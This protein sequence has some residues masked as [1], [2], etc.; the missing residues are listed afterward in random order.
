MPLSLAAM[1]R[2][3]RALL[4]WVALLAGATLAGA[5]MFQWASQTDAAR[6]RVEQVPRV[7][8]W[9]FDQAQKDLDEN[10]VW[11]VIEGPA[12][13]IPYKVYAVLSPGTEVP[14]SSFLVASIPARGWRP[15]LIWVGFSLL[16]QLLV[17]FGRPHWRVGI[18]ALFWLLS[19]TLYWF[20]V[21]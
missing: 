1:Y 17:R 16:G 7:K 18:C 19:T 15:L 3:K 2:P 11:G 13:G 12:Q 5:L 21:G 10:G 14:V 4:H 9:M 20:K 8:A 6:A